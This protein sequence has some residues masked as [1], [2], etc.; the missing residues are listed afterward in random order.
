MPAF[1]EAVAVSPG[2]DLVAT[3]GQDGAVRLRTTD[4]GRALAAW[5]W[6]GCQLYAAAFAPDG[7]WLATGARDSTVKLWPVADLLREGR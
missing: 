3:V 5:E 7:R 4:D 6:D 1:Y 2:G